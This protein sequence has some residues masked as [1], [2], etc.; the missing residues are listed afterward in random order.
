MVSN[1]FSFFSFLCLNILYLFITEFRH[2][3]Q[4]FSSFH[5]TW[6]FLIFILSLIKQFFF[7]FYYLFYIYSY[8]NL[9]FVSFNFIL[10]PCFSRIWNTYLDCVLD[11]LFFHP[12]IFSFLNIHLHPSYFLPYLLLPAS[13]PGFFEESSHFFLVYLKLIIKCIQFSIKGC[14]YSGLCHRTIVSKFYPNRLLS[15]LDIQSKLSYTAFVLKV[16]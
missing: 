6:L 15:M 14:A 10:F 7:L 3:M 2:V 5:F 11:F 8:P 1:V 13:Y 4:L 12:N 9:H 16:T